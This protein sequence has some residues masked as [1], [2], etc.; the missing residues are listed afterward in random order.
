MG[1][2]NNNLCLNCPDKTNGPVQD[3][4]NEWINT[5][6]PTNQLCHTLQAGSTKNW[7]KNEVELA[8]SKVSTD[9]VERHWIYDGPSC[10]LLNPSLAEHNMPCLSKQCRSRS[11]GF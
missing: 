9:N 10:H 1:A 3:I 4:T 11:G 7:L 6:I 8:V 5:P 2:E